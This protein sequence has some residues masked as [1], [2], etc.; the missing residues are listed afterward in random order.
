MKGLVGTLSGVF[1][2]KAQSQDGVLDLRPCQ[3]GTWTFEKSFSLLL[4]S[5]LGFDVVGVGAVRRGG[6][7]LGSN[8]GA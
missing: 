8:L 6:P 3:L 1:S 4:P 7:R 5:V 2:T